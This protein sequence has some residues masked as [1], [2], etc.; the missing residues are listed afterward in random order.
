MNENVDDWEDG[1]AQELY[2][3]VCHSASGKKQSKA[4]RELGK[5]ARGGSS[6]AAYA[7]RLIVRNP[8]SNGNQELALEELSK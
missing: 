5:L 2:M 6:N 3:T 7:L 1:K 8:N 4:I